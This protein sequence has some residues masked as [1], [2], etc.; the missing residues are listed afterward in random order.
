MTID[1]YI[2]RGSR[3]SVNK[4]LSVVYNY[5]FEPSGNFQTIKENRTNSGYVI[6]P[7][8]A[9][10]ISEGYGK[11]RLFITGNR[12]YSFTS[13][14]DKAI[15]LISEN[16]FT[17]FPNVNKFEFETDSRVLE[18]FQ[19]EKALSTAGMTAI[20]AVWSNEQNEC[21]PGIKISSMNGSVIIPL[22]DAIPLVEM[23]KHF[24]P[25]V[26]SISMLRFF[27]KIE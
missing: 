16:L 7:T 10:T 2:F 14:L 6:Y 1:T 24:D 4:D 23:L 9:I 12:Y 26:Y 17:I 25:I 5:K 19:N 8:Y 13:L 18:R 20:P 22:E 21:F 3:D 11:Q 15:K 27:G